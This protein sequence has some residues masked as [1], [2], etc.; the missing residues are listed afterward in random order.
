MVWIVSRC[1]MSKD[2][3]GTRSQ[4]NDLNT[5]PVEYKLLTRCAIG[6]TRRFVDFLISVWPSP[7]RC[8]F[9]SAT[10]CIDMV[11]ANRDAWSPWAMLTVLKAVWRTR[12]LWFVELTL[13]ELSS[14]AGVVAQISSSFRLWLSRATMAKW[15]QM[16]PKDGSQMLSQMLSQM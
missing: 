13:P 15:C 10:A 4:L 5:A 14:P 16:E 3:W 9:A 7:T 1:R 6:I 2:A 12:C 8:P 11:T